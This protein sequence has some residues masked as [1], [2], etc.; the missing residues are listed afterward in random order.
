VLTWSLQSLGDYHWVFD[1]VSG[2]AVIASSY[3]GLL[4]KNV[5]ATIRSEVK[6]IR[7]EQAT[8][9][10]QLLEHQNLVKDELADHQAELVEG[11]HDLRSEFREKHAENKQALA[12][13]V[14]D[15]MRQFEGLKGI[16]QR[17]DKT[18]EKIANGH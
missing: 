14:N 5:L 3:V 7:L 2:V 10:A 16:L 1:I 12:V 13:H 9:K 8:A 18:V 17:I 15:D 4:I 11:Q 6:D